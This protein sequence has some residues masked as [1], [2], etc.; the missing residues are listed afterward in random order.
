M[1]ED[2]S[3]KIKEMIKNFS[4]KDFEF[5]KPVE[6]LYF[7]SGGLTNEDMKKEI[8]G[9]KN[10][11]FTEKRKVK[12]EIRYTLYFIYSN[13]RGRAYALTFRNKIRLITVFPLGRRT[14]KKYK[15]R[16]FKNYCV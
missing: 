14:L 2:Y 16:K 7:L 9:C 1:T 11:E 10:L 12:G 6:L 3:E 15:R 8:L 13:K 5:G 4:E